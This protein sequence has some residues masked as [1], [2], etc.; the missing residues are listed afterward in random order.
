MTK[1]SVQCVLLSVSV[2]T[3]ALQ[4]PPMSTNGCSQHLF[5][6]G[7]PPLSPF[8]STLLPAPAG[9]SP[10]ETSSDPALS[11]CSPAMAQAPF[12]MVELPQLAVVLPAPLSLVHGSG[13]GTI[14]ELPSMATPSPWQARLP[15]ASVLGALAMDAQVLA[16]LLH[17]PGRVHQTSSPLGCPAGSP[18]PPSAHGA[19]HPTGRNS[20]LPALCARSPMAGHLMFT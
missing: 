15:Q 3:G 1:T 20:A 19:R 2:Q 13:Q 10:S 8:P 5:K 18:A 17:A 6:N 11:R 4:Q 7:S 16:P 9:A 14:S 12:P